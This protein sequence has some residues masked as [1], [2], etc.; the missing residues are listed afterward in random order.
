LNNS[1]R[2]LKILRRESVDR[3]PWAP[4]LEQWFEINKFQG[5]LPVPYKDKDLLEICDDLGTSPR[6]YYFFQDT[7]KTIQG[8]DCE[9]KT[10]ED[11]EKIVTV[12]STPKGKLKEVKRKSIRGLSS[13]AVAPYWSE[14]LVKEAGDLPALKYLLENQ[15]FEFDRDSYERALAKVGGRGPPALYCP[16]VPIA[17]LT[18]QH[19]GLMKTHLLL[20]KHPNEMTDLLQTLD[21]NTDR[22]LEVFMK[23]PMQLLLFDDNIDR[24][25]FSPPI[26][27]QHIL[28]Y[29][30]RRSAELHANGRLCVAHWDGKLKSLLQ[31]ARETSLDGLECVTPLPQG[32]VTLEEIHSA[33]GDMVLMDGIP[34]ILLLPW[35]GDAELE[36]FTRELLRLFLPHLVAGVADLVPA[37]ANIEKVRLVTRLLDAVQ[38]A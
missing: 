11:D 25:L 27:V 12:Y 6:T 31:Y 21:N 10:V 3:V 1:E 16:A 4:R 18:I 20:K 23:T 5:T 7:I 22:F 13:R 29:Y 17:M 32:D 9:V 19:I 30:K 8:G 28:P 34:S 2:I 35:V 38:N 36:A 24:N 37:D 33:L 14:H 15:S 26:F